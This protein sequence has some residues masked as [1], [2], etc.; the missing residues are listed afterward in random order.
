MPLLMQARP[1][2]DEIKNDLKKQINFYQ[3]NSSILMN[4]FIFVNDEDSASKVYV[5]NKINLG[6]KLGIK[7]C[8][9]NYKTKQDILDCLEGFS[10]PFIIQEPALISQ[11]EIQEILNKYS[12]RDMDCFGS[13]AFGDMAF[14]RSN[15]WPCT[16]AG[17]VK[18]LE[19]YHIMDQINTVTI[20]GRSKI[21]GSPLEIILRDYYNKTVTVCHSKTPKDVIKTSIE[22][23][24]LIVSAV[25][26][27]GA[28]ENF[29]FSDKVLVDV[30]IN[31]NA[32]YY[33]K[34]VGD[35]M[36]K[37][38]YESRAYTPVPGGVGP[39]TVAM[40][41]QNVVEFYEEML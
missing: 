39:M 20:L 13:H 21:V 1:I 15:R 6:N 12:E 40:L 41:M 29:N 33:K 7:V 11:E 17:I 30:G 32:V 23:S 31:K 26:I 8:T 36:P 9:L 18:L 35:F 19:Y 22:N 38:Y 2:V 24:D 37:N 16:P 14:K 27:Y 34:I 3:N 5:K 28:F 25:G 4:L 10:G